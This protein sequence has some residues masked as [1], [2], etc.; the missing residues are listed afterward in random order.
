MYILI[1]LYYTQTTFIF[2]SNLFYH[3]SGN[4]NESTCYSLKSREKRCNFFKVFLSCLTHVLFPDFSPMFILCLETNLP[5]VQ[6][7]CGLCIIGTCLSDLYAVNR[8]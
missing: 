5:F 4:G 2:F 6:H 1:I 3:L 7:Y 8:L